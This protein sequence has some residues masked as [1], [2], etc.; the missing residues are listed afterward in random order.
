MNNIAC[1]VAILLLGAGCSLH[2]DMTLADVESKDD[3]VEVAGTTLAQDDF[4]KGQDLVHEFKATLPGKTSE[5]LVEMFIT[6]P[7]WGCIAVDPPLYVLYRDGNEAVKEELRS[8]GR[9]AR[10]T[11][12]NYQHDDRSLFTGD[13]GSHMTI[14]GVCL[15]L[16]GELD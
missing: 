11:L 10:P 3:L 6:H 9:S 1:V 4:A 16:L 15:E 2:R 8:R 5:E 14:G 13:N 12:I 7:R